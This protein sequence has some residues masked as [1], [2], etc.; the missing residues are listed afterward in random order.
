MSKIVISLSYELSRMF[1]RRSIF[2]GLIT[3]QNSEQIFWSN[4]VEEFDIAQK[5]GTDKISVP[6]GLDYFLELLLIIVKI[7]RR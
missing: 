5:R 4:F 3:E 1:L 2:V 6:I 7:F